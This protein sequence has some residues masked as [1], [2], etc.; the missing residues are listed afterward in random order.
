MRKPFLIHDLIPI[1]SKFPDIFENS[2]PTFLINYDKKEIKKNEVAI[3]SC[4][5][6]SE[7]MS[8]IFAD[9]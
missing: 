9:Q 2:P 1:P 7:E 3:T 6:L 4:L 8:S 5:A